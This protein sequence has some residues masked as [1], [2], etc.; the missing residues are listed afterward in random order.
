[1]E[2]GQ[3]K[4][5]YL[6]CFT[7]QTFWQIFCNP[8]FLDLNYGCVSVLSPYLYPEAH[9]PVGCVSIMLFSNISSHSGFP[10]GI[11]K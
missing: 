3:K 4:G 5:I 8:H 2:S 10:D 6:F 11:P 1:M 9:P 7:Q